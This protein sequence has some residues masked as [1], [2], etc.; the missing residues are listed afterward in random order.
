MPFTILSAAVKMLA[1]LYVGVYDT[2][3]VL[4][5]KSTHLYPIVVRGL[6]QSDIS[7]D[8]KLVINTYHMIVDYPVSF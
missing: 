2:F 3:A 7:V 6:L 5:S 8:R 4:S 1:V